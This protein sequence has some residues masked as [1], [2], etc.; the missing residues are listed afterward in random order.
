MTVH[1]NISNS[2]TPQQNS[3]TNVSKKPKL[4]KYLIYCR[5][6]ASGCN[7]FN[8]NPGIQKK[9]AELHLCRNIEA[10]G[11]NSSAIHKTALLKLQL[12]I[13]EIAC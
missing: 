13:A 4:V 9:H 2:L 7:I 12:A 10:D 6:S 1:C 11:K 5:N 8:K 3:Q